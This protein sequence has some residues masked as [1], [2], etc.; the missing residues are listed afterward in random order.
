MK[1]TV[2]IILL[3]LCA[4]PGY[5]QG[6]NKT[7]TE[8]PQTDTIVIHHTSSKPG[9]TW[10]KLSAIQKKT[11]YTADPNNPDPNSVLILGEEY[12]SEHFRKVGKKKIEVYYA[13]HYLIR[14]NGKAE[15]LLEDEDIGWHSNNWETNERS[16]AICLD[17]DYSKNPPPE[18][19]LKAVGRLLKRYSKEY[20]LKK[21]LAHGDIRQTECPGSWYR[22]KNKSNLTGRERILKYAGIKDKLE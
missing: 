17:G 21:I 16:I 18:K 9:I 15:R 7:P 19:M 12:H 5:S 1:T 8:E 14:T 13:Y 22:S 11:L 6:Q 20:D 10:Q 4:E 3:F 2:L